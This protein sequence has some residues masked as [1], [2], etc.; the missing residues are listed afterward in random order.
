MATTPDTT[1][2]LRT[3]F[4]RR[5]AAIDLIVLGV[6]FV[7][8]LVHAQKG[9]ITTKDDAFITFRYAEHL[10]GGHGIVWNVGEA[11][12]EGYTN[13]LFM[14]I[15]SLFALFKANL[16]VAAKIVNLLSAAAIFV[17]LVEI[18]T[19]IYDNR[20]VLFFGVFLFVFPFFTS[21]HIAGGLETMFYAM[22]VT[23]ATLLL[24]RQ[25]TAYSK[26]RQALFALALLALGLT[27]PEGVLVAAVL[28]LL[29]LAL[30]ER[31]HRRHCLTALA[32]WYV[33]P[34]ALY[35]AGRVIYFGYWLPNPFYIKKSDRLF[36]LVG[37]IELQ[38]FVLATKLYVGLLLLPFVSERARKPLLVLAAVFV[39]SLAVYMFFR[40]MMNYAFRYY[41]PYYALMLPVMA[42]PLFVLYRLLVDRRGARELPE[43][44]RHPARALLLVAAVVFLCPYTGLARD[45]VLGR[46]VTKISNYKEFRYWRQ[47]GMKLEDC[48]IY[49]G[50]FLYRYPEYKDRYIAL[51][52]VGAIPYYSQWK[53]L[54]MGG[55]NDVH[56]AHFGTSVSR[57][58]EQFATKF[59]LDYVFEK[60]P[61]VV[62]VASSNPVTV[63]HYASRILV[64][65]PR[66]QAYERI[67][68]FEYSALIYE[69]IYIKKDDPTL[70]DLR[71]GLV[72]DA[73]SRGAMQIEAKE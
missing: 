54:D 21:A 18:F 14:V 7:M 12:V 27:R 48:H 70:K 37:L 49:I 72:E 35:M 13:F 44:L 1:L 50:K 16:V 30:V 68:A 71:D 65:D 4:T 8:L 58:M 26:R 51:G 33:A 11:P 42:A 6:L 19:R 40:P 45:V 17:M 28:I 22:L 66:F 32:L 20:Y 62:M 34:A 25:W 52:D 36:S 31:R 64:E 5:L 57:E 2:N 29:E 60:D 53:A 10:A 61:A 38:Q 3:V 73:M 15:M 41:Q 24:L 67:V 55:L 56:M 46:E 39:P 63:D 9:W 59:D 43:A 23:L 69:F 47:Q